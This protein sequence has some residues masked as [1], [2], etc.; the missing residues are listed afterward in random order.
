[1]ISRCL[2]CRCSGLAPALCLVARRSGG[3]ERTCGRSQHS[4]WSVGNPRFEADGA[5][6]L[7]GTN[8]YSLATSRFTIRPK[9]I[10]AYSL[11]EA[12]GPQ[13]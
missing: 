1:M 5:V 9:S 13:R 12:K 6:T 7:E 4:F 11:V 10:G 3:Q 8:P 2:T